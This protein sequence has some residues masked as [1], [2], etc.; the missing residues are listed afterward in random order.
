MFGEMG[1]T[2]LWWNTSFKNGVE[3][4]YQFFLVNAD[5]AGFYQGLYNQD[6][7]IKISVRCVE[8]Y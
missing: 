6:P 3:G 2:G 1:T 7:G 4:Q 8:D 5:D